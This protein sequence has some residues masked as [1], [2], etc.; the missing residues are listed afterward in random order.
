MAFRKHV[1]PMLHIPR[2]GNRGGE[3]VTTFPLVPCNGFG[4]AFPL[5]V[6]SRQV[7]VSGREIKAGEKVVGA[8]PGVWLLKSGAA[9]KRGLGNVP[10]GGSFGPIIPHASCFVRLPKSAPSY[11]ALFLLLVLL[12]PV[13]QSG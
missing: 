3:F 10:S 5:G 9:S 13:M 12:E 2:P 7:S 1:L 6:E 4:L 11:L 8:S